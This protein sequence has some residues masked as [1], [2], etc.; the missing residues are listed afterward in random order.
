[1]TI[2]DPTVSLWAGVESFDAEAIDLAL[3]QLLL[4]LPLDRAVSEAILPLLQE[5][6]ARWETGNLSIAHEHFLTGLVMRRLSVLAPRP[7]V[8]SG[9]PVVVLACPPGERH[10]I[11]L[12]CFGLLLGEQGFRVRYLGA[13]TPVTSVVAAARASAADAVVL[14]ATR[15]TALTAHASTLRKLG[16]R[17]AVYVAGRGA[18]AEVAELVGGT[19]LPT[20]H[21]A[22]VDALVGH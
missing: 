15:R 14:A 19:L 9:A 22:A 10:E 1:M 17:H 12:L 11:A 18:D 8:T 13:D 20:D 6:G 2:T 5:V 21:A 16:E 4:H 3:S 7:T